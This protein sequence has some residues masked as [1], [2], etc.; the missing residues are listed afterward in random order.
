MNYF[1]KKKLAFMSIV[2]RV[3]GFIRTITG[4]LPLTLE[5]CVDEE[6]IIDYTLYGQSV[7][8]GTPT[9]TTPIEVE[10]VG[11]YDESVG[12]YKIP[13]AISDGTRNI[14][15]SIY[16]DEPLRK[17]GDYADYIKSVDLVN[18]TGKVVRKVG[19]NKLLANS[20]ISFTKASTGSSTMNRYF[21]IPKPGI[22]SAQT[23]KGVGYCTVLRKDYEVWNTWTKPQIYFGMANNSIGIVVPI[24]IEHS[25]P[26]I[27]NYLSSNGENEVVI[28]Y[29]L[30]TPT[31]TPITL[32]KI[33]T[34]K[35]T[36]ILTADTTIQPSNAEI[37][38]YSN[39]KE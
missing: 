33:P 35:G 23:S 36:S 22:K 29:Q 18:G 15:T 25:Y 4:A 38:Y 3:K 20:N 13:I 24:N 5:G 12:K 31:E 27:Y 21:Y 19:V 14:T 16:L 39:V 8:N 32:P 6:S 10:S 26:A 30:A 37:T 7:Q 17:V 11:E 1:Q 2:N 28:Y 9:P 34:F